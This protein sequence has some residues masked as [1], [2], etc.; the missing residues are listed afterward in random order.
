MLA[1]LQGYA[2]I[3]P[4]P[5]DVCNVKA[6]IKFLSACNALFERGL[7]SKNGW[8]SDTPNPITDSIKKDTYSFVTGM[9]SCSAM[10]SINMW[11]LYLSSIMCVLYR[12]LQ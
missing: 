3:S 2:S 11:I 9:T 7:L 6:V 8:I 12:V 10:V 4:P 5:P 1:E